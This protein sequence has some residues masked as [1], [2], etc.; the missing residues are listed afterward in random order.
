MVPAVPVALRA[1]L[2]PTQ[3]MPDGVAVRF[4]GVAGGLGS[5]KVTTKPLLPAGHKAELTLIFV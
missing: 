1:M 4:V 3:T 5:V 2:V